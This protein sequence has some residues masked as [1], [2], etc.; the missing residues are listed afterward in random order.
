VAGGPERVGLAAWLCH[1]S[2]AEYQR[3]CPPAHIA[4]GGAGEGDCAVSES[5][6]PQPTGQHH[7]RGSD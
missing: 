4:C 3:C 1:Q 6:D 7:D 5:S 2:D